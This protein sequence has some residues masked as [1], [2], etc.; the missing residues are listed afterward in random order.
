MPATNRKYAAPSGTSA[1][2]ATSRSNWGGYV[3]CPGDS[4][5][6]HDSEAQYIESG[7]VEGLD[8]YERIS[9]LG[10]VNFS[11]SAIVGLVILELCGEMV[12]DGGASGHENRGSE[13]A[14]SGKE[15]AQLLERA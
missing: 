10:L 2:G 15:E 5:S 9:S 8:G 3:Q 12:A 7:E 1:K 6:G 14:G 13:E 4:S 11:G